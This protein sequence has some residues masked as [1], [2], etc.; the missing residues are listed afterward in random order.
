MHI[1]RIP[2]PHSLKDEDR[3]SLIASTR[4][5]WLA[6]GLLAALGSPCRGEELVAPSAG[7]PVGVPAAFAPAPVADGSVAPSDLPAPITAQT[8]HSV[9]AP[10]RVCGPNPCGNGTSCGL[11]DSSCCE[12]IWSDDRL[13]GLFAHSDYC[14][15]RFISPISNPLFFEDPRTLTEAHVVFANQWIP[16]SNP[17]F[18]GGNAQYVA[19]QLRAALTER[20]SIVANKDGYLWIDGN[21]EAAIPD[22]DGWA[23]MTAGLKY[24]LIRDPEQQFI[25]S[26]GVLYELDIG[27][28][29]VFQGQGDGEFHLFLTGGSEIADRWHYLTGSGFRLPTDTNVRSQMWYWSHHLDYEFAERWYGLVELNWFHWMRSGE[30]LPVNFEGGDLMNLGSTDV[31]G[32]DIVTAAFGG[33]KRFGRMSEIGLAYE[34]PL[35]DRKDLL[36][37]RLYA[38]LILRY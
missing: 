18:N 25:V 16:G 3:M 8:S 31:A 6:L 2:L 35:T 7:Q 15:S 10:G 38:D 13:F 33:R 36:Q 27:S 11:T 28:H 14:F 34:V 1:D 21:N 5:G 17:V 29:K 22:Q 12:E 24:N 9:P 20:L 26:T 32:N 37:S 19:T 23:D 4:R 30:A